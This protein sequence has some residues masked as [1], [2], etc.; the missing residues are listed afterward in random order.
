MPAHDPLH[1]AGG[2]QP[3]Q[4]VLEGQEEPALAEVALPAGAATQLVV[5]PSALVAFAAE[6]VETAELADHRPLLVAPA[7]DLLELALVLG[8][9]FIRVEVQSGSDHLATGETFGVAAEKDVDP[10]SGHVRR[11]GH[12]V[13]PACLAHDL[14]LAGMLLCVKHLVRDP[15]FSKRRESCS[16]FATDAVPTSTGWPNA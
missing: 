4:L 6:H 2:E 3:H 15:R 16:D 8:L 7:P 1:R 10:S 13:E 5:D 14:R 9:A 11:H 12:P